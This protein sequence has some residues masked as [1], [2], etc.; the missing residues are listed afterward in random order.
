MSAGEKRVKLYERLPE[1]YRIRDAE[2]D[3]PGQLQSY[4]GIAEEALGA[5]HESIESLY[6]DL[7]IETCDP[8][9]IPYIADLLGTSH[10]KGDPWAIR[11]DV[12]DTIALRRRKG[13]LGGLEKLT[14]DLTQWHTHCVELRE[15]LAWNQHINH[16]RPDDSGRGWQSGIGSAPA[17]GGMA[18]IRAGARLDRLN[19]PYDSFARMP[20]LKP[21]AGDVPRYNL[22]NL[23]V[24]LW[25]LKDYRIVASRPVPLDPEKIRALKGN[26]AEVVCFDV[27]P[28]GY[29]VRLFNA[30]GTEAEDDML[31]LAGIDKMPGPIL[32]SQLD[33]P[34]PV[35]GD[36]GCVSIGTYDP[37]KPPEEI[38]PT[39]AGLQL[40]MPGGFFGS[41]WKI[42]GAD[43]S[44]LTRGLT[45]RLQGREIAVD[46]TIGRI[47][48]GADQEDREQLEKELIVT[49]T[50]GAVG[51]VGAHPVSRLSGGEDPAPAQDLKAELQRAQAD[52]SAST[53]DIM[54]DDNSV[55]DLDIDAIVLD[56]PLVIRAA[57]E[58]RPIVRLSHPLQF[59]AEDQRRKDIFVRLEGLHITRG[60]GF[61]AAPVAAP[62]SAAGET[63]PGAG[64]TRARK[65]K[66][67][68][69]SPVPEP[70]LIEQANLRKLEISG[71]TLDPGCYEKKDG[72]IAYTGR[73]RP[74]MCL[75]GP[76]TLEYAPAIEIV[77]S[78]TGP[79]LIDHGYRLS[80]KD[81]IVDAGCGVRD[82]ADSGSLAISGAAEGPENAW[83]PVTDVDGVTVFG[84]TLV[85]QISGL[86]GIWVHALQAF[87][88]Q[89]G[90][91]RFSYFPDEDN[92]L[93][94]NY[95]C[96]RGPGVRLKFTSERFG[97]PA[98]G[99][100]SRLADFRIRERGPDDDAMGAFG[101]LYEAHKWRNLQIRF[102]EFMPAGTRLLIIPYT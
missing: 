93:P 45:P 89:K 66:A 91:V 20:D 50:Y 14:F 44:D 98:Y 26:A 92:E 56:R 16:L 67:A 82:A 83:G 79:L 69:V 64:S 49:Y 96:A 38:K 80:L 87:N 1:I 33:I 10:L 74:S 100:L 3:P 75:T 77:Q 15:N 35:G 5:V 19:T 71:C 13:T 36:G 9:V 48:F 8:W 7:F 18:M 55:H 39:D 53:L 43:L 11:A 52:R 84:R 68:D 23:A 32:F 61:C 34:D 73:M 59:L 102:R 24:Y 60:D 2:Q 97:D 25:R 70:A 54:I 17:R 58:K 28:L 31:F 4:L 22:P 12:A 47:A 21:P 94:Q 27:H 42:R 86:G 63:V 101:F 62:P 90:C 46:P 72:L 95:Q 85:E 51:P 81:S 29:P 57:S 88:N 99:Q 76:D 6:D 37:G 65:A 30:H 40:Y 78:I 41:G